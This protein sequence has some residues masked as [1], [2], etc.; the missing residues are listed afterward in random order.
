LIKLKRRRDTQ[1]IGTQPNDTQH[2]V[3]NSTNQQKTTLSVV[4]AFFHRV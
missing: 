2:N 4:F 1:P 3:L